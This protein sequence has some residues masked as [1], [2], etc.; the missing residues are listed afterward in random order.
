MSSTDRWRLA[1]FQ[2]QH[3]PQGP[4]PAPTPAAP[5]PIPVEV[6]P[7]PVAPGAAP[8]EMYATMN[9]H[10]ERKLAKRAEANLKAKKQTQYTKAFREKG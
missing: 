9:S 3:A 10:F 2:H 5:M 7:I 4:P 1:P 8:E 6:A